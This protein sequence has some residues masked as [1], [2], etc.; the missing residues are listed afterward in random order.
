MVGTSQAPNPPKAK[1]PI[2]KTS[3]T[4]LVRLSVP[5]DIFV[6]SGSSRYM[7]ITAMA[8]GI[9]IGWRKLMIFAPAQITAPRTTTRRST[10]QAVSAAH[11]IFCCQGVGYSFMLRFQRL[12]SNVTTSD[13]FFQANLCQLF[14]W[15]PRSCPQAFCFLDRAPA[16]FAR[17][18]ALPACGSISGKCRQY[19]QT[20][21][22]RRAPLPLRRE[23]DRSKPDRTCPYEIPPSQGCPDK[24]RCLVRSRARFFFFSSRRRHTR[25]TCD[26]S[27]DV[28]SSDLP[29]TRRDAVSVETPRAGSAVGV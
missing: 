17:R 26:W 10:K 1:K 28:C 19:V 15:C 24:R 11:I 7:R 25:L 12:T 14:S 27:S 3:A 5:R 2:A 21:R 16:L 4:A 6:T 13:S 29:A 23:A 8:T 9:R 22:D 20:R 18:P